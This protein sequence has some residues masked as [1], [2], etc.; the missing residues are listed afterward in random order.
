ME[1]IRTLW[2]VA[3]A[4]LAVAAPGCTRMPVPAGPGN[5]AL[6]LEMLP[7]GFPREVRVTF[8]NTSDRPILLTMPIATP[9][10]NPS[11]SDEEL[12][13]LGDLDENALLPLLVLRLSPDVLETCWPIY[14]DVASKHQPTPVTVTLSSGRQHSETYPLSAF[15]LW[16]ACGPT[17][18]IVDVLR[19]GSQ[20]L[21]VQA[22]LVWLHPT[23]A[24][25]ASHPVTI[26][27][28]IPDSF[29][30]KGED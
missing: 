17:N 29:R 13:R 4:A 19:P 22:L 16:G 1:R 11:I 27:C 12:A 28:T 20:P 21:A 15:Y 23:W 26:R 3:V 14:T 2:I 18:S 9:S 5:L 30:E 25:V 10:P 7:E 24:D 8:R 6:T